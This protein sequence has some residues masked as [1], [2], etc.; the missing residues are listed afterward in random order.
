M[1]AKVYKNKS[2]NQLLVILSRKQLKLK[3]KKTPKLID[4]KKYELE[5]YV[6]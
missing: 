4:I 6:D 2:N 1:K 3:N 5:D